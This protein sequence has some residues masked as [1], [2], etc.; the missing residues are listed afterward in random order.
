MPGLTIWRKWI[1]LGL[2]LVPWWAILVAV[3]TFA[4]TAMIR[5]DEPDKWLEGLVQMIRN[6][7]EFIA[8][9][10]WFYSII[11]PVTVIVFCQALMLIPTVSPP[12][13]GVHSRRWFIS[14]AVIAFFAA[15]LTLGVLMGLMELIDVWEDHFWAKPYAWLSI[16]LTMAV[17]WSIWTWV[18]LRYSRKHDVTNINRI[19]G[20]LL[21]GTV[22]EMI[23]LVPIDVM[24]RRR[25]DCCCETGTYWGMIIGLSSMLFLAGPGVL[26]L[27]G[28]HRH[29]AWSRNHCYRCGYSKGPEPRGRCPECGADWT[30]GGK[31]DRRDSNPRPPGP[32]PGA[33]A[34]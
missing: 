13:K 21:S 12:R 9:E 23:V 26:V 10:G 4:I 32:Q 24:V 2:L 3:A 28:K 19:L 33:L 14:F 11:I 5:P 8:D 17:S 30:D 20:L 27:L 16:L 15:T 25:N 29:H 6:P 22:I 1:L 18:I 7:E 34:D 31:G